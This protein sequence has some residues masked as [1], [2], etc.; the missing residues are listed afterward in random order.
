MKIDQARK[1]ID[2]IGEE[3]EFIKRSWIKKQNINVKFLEQRTQQINEL[4][5]LRSCKCLKF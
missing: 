5:E 3:I 4:N 2:A 1:E